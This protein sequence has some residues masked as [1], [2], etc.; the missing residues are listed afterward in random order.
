MFKNLKDIH[1]RQ[2]NEVKISERIRMLESV[3]ALY[4]D[5]KIDQEVLE[6]LALEIA[7]GE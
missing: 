3:K 4:S 5:G 1:E 7:M 6:I 2:L